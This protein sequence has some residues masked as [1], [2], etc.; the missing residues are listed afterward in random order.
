VKPDLVIKGGHISYAAIGDANASIPTPEPSFYKPMWSANHS[1]SSLVFVS[2]A[3]VKTNTVNHF[4]LKKRIVTVKGINGVKK[5]DMIFNNWCKP[6]T[7]QPD[8]FKVFVPMDN[9]KGEEELVELTCEP[10]KSLPLTK[11]YFFF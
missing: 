9:E 1:A 2:H 11:R 8:K 4:N 6:I 5:K 3:S 10:A 7:V